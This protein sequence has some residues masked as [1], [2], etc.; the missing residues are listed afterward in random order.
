MKNL[1]KKLLDCYFEMYR[2]LYDCN[3]VKDKKRKS[4]K[5]SSRRSTSS[6]NVYSEGNNQS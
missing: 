5:N 3:T 6:K 1:L 4:Q 2:V